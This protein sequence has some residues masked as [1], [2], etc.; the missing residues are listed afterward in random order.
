MNFN[1]Y[2]VSMADLVDRVPPPY[3]F[4]GLIRTNSVVVV[5]GAVHSA[6]SMMLMDLMICGEYGLPFLDY[7]KPV[8][9][10]KSYWIGA[11]APDWDYGAQIRKLS[12]GH[13]ISLAMQKTLSAHGIVA[14]SLPFTPEFVD[15]IHA[16]HAELGFDC[17]FIDTLR[18]TK[19]GGLVEN[20]NDD[21]TLYMNLIKEFRTKL[22]VTVFLAHHATKQGG[23][24][25]RIGTDQ[26]AGGTPITGSVEFHFHLKRRG[27]R[28]RM[29]LCKARG[30]NLEQQIPSFD[31]LE[32]P[33]GRED[34]DGVPIWGLKLSPTGAGRNDILLLSLAAGDL[35]RAD[36]LG[37]FGAHEL[38][39]GK[40]AQQ[41]A[42]ATDNAIRDCRINGRIL[43]PQR[44]T[45][46]LRT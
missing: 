26:A 43:S 39:R 11:D 1:E 34:S 16:Q 15:F 3:L 31:L 9:P 7:F 46:R 22:G 21:M 37:I 30:Q 33:T 38:Y 28:V 4:Q 45:F 36:L 24:V 19:P 5:T 2:A 35:T 27:V 6:K 18:T 13:G 42:Y 32:T 14:D 20:S 25:E 41:V 29:E 8:N 44:G 40:T 23:P 17:L 10:F 12:D